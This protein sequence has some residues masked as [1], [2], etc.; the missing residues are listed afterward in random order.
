M[1]SVL[2]YLLETLNDCNNPENNLCSAYIIDGI[3]ITLYS[4]VLMLRPTSGA[5]ESCSGGGWMIVQ[6]HIIF[7]SLNFII[8]FPSHIKY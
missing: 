7:C 6:V 4:Q 5:T 2:H 8:L 3:S 1:L